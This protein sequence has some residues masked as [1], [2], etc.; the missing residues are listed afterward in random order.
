MFNITDQEKWEETIQD[1]ETTDPLLGGENG[2]LTQASQKLANRTTWLKAVHEALSQTVSNLGDSF[3][4]LGGSASNRFKVAAAINDNEAVNR[5]QLSTIIT[6][7]VDA[8]NGND[9]NDGSS[10]SEAFKTVDE[11]V[12]NT[13]YGSTIILKDNQTHVLNYKTNIRGKSITIRGIGSADTSNT[14]FINKMVDN[15]NTSGF[16]SFEE[17]AWLSVLFLTL[18]TVDSG[19][20]IWNGFLQKRSDSRGLV[21]IRGSYLKIECISPLVRCASGPQNVN[22][23]LYGAEVVGD[24]KL[25]FNDQG[26]SFVAFTGITL[27]ANKTLDDYLY[28]PTRKGVVKSW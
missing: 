25:I 26:V 27:P 8:V 21:V 17:D 13:I 5:G 20:T 12:R 7:Y 2:H 22:I 9:E 14:I 3:A 10:F 23:S 16:V 1:L 19:D 6:F 15:T 18:K 24:G 28:F 11:A 4:A